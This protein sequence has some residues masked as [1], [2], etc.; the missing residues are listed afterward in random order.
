MTQGNV[1]SMRMRRDEGQRSWVE[2]VLCCAGDG[3]LGEGMLWEGRFVRLVRAGASQIQGGHLSKHGW[4]V[5]CFSAQLFIISASMT[6]LC[7]LFLSHSLSS[8][9]PTFTSPLTP[10]SRLSLVGARGG[11]KEDGR[12]PLHAK[13][14]KKKCGE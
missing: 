14:V 8:H 3:R 7:R 5:F 2:E 1:C 12:V 13:Q 11:R 4:M 6:L 9:S 10:E